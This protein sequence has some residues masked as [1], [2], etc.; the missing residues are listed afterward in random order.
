MSH[1][2]DTNQSVD[3]RSLQERLINPVTV[4]DPSKQNDEEESIL[5][6]L[7]R[8]RQ[9]EIIQKV[10]VSQQQEEMSNELVKFCVCLSLFELRLKKK[11][12][13]KFLDQF[14]Q[15]AGGARCDVAHPPP[16]DHIAKEGA[17]KRY[18][19][20][21]ATI[22]QARKGDSPVNLETFHH[23]LKQF[24][25]SYCGLHVGNW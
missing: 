6:D 17:V 9:I 21:E 19:A 8:K 24:R 5:A 15:S 13:K 10:K 11:K 22:V 1:K 18:P 16:A 23:H 20:L 14:D 2:T 12:Q 7:S 25:L 3:G 4:H